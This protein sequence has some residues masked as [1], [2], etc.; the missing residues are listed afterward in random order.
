MT[1]KSGQ[2]LTPDSTILK[3]PNLK[4]TEKDTYARLS[5]VVP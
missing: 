4:L 1:E 3:F 2:N 5:I